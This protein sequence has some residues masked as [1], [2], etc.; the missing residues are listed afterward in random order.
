VNRG[1]SDHFDGQRFFNPA[2]TRNP[3]LG[4]LRRMLRTPR[5]P[6][7]VRMALEPSAPRKREND[8]EIVF[9]FIGH[10]SFLIQAP[11]GNILTDP[12]YS[13]RAGPFG[14]V[15]PRRVRLPAVAREDLP[16]I[17]VVLLSH[18][19]YDHCDL[20]MLRWIAQRFAP[21]FVTPLA[22]ARL[23]RRTGARRIEEVDWWET[24]ATTPF[25][26]TLTPAQH[27]SARTPFDHNRALWGG[28]H[29]TVGGQ[30]IFFAGDTGYAPFFSEIRERLGAPDVA[31]LPI[32]A[33]EPRWFMQPIHMNPEEA[34]RAHI[35]LRSAQ[36]IATHYGT[37]QLTLEGIDEPA[38]ALRAALEANGIPA[39]RFR[40]MLT[41]SIELSC[42]VMTPS[43]IA[44][45]TTTSA[46]FGAFEAA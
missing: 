39:E 18:N 41:A 23:L 11:E 34:L 31:L 38:R 28:F 35:E 32:G 10:S 45:E 40:V 1:K 26:V 20:A 43:R 2:G 27:F 8:D 9:T 24:A 17:S 36:S 12:V 16:P 6:W 22:N 29:F 5:V 19:H 25:P 33:Y 4:E 21:V 3:T 14:I 37:F 46:H 7:P 42:P 44:V 30:R 15:G 13:G